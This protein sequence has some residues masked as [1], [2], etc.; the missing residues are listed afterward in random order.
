MKEDQDHLFVVVVE[1][2]EFELGASCL[3]G[4]CLSA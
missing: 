3:L 2:L 4:T 1:V